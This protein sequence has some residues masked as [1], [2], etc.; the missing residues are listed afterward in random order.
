MTGGQNVLADPQF[1]MATVLRPFTGF[2]GVYAGKDPRVPVAFFP[3]NPEGGAPQVLDDQAGRTGYDP[4]LLR[5]LSVPQGS[6]MLVAI[7]HCITAQDGDILETVYRYTFHWRWR[8]SAALRASMSAGKGGKPYHIRYYKGRP[9]SSSGTAEERVLIPSATRT[10]VV[11]QTEVSGNLEQN[12]RLRRERI[13]VVSTFLD[14]TILP[15]LPDGTD[16]VHQQGVLDPAQF[17]TAFLQ[18]IAKSS[19]F[20]TFEF[21]CEADELLI[22]ATREDA[23]QDTPTPDDWTFEGAAAVDAPFSNLYGTNVGGVQGASGDPQPL[24]EGLGIY[25]FVGA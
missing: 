3:P 17:A 12:Q 13:D 25:V 6:R 10:V 20:M 7:P 8:N 1:S 23:Y 24:S 11:E 2:E 22:D 5:Y 9:D 16:G 21:R 14:S 15:L 4:K 19:L 18:R